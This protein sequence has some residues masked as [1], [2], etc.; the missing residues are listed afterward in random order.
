MVMRPNAG[1]ELVTQ[2]GNG[3]CFR[4]IDCSVSPAGQAIKPVEL[5]PGALNIGESVFGGHAVKVRQED[6]IALAL[7]PGCHKSFTFIEAGCMVQGRCLKPKHFARK[8]LC[9]PARPAPA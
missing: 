7:W 9:A 3:H 1:F 2:A 5:T 4:R 8:K 6:A